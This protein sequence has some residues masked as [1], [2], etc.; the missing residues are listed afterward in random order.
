MPGGG[1]FVEVAASAEQPRETGAGF[2][3]ESLCRQL[4]QIKEERLLGSR[5]R[6]RMEMRLLHH[7]M[8]LDHRI[9]HIAAT[10]APVRTEPHGVI[11]FLQVDQI[12]RHHQTFT[13][14]ARHES[15]PFEQLVRSPVL[16][17]KTSC[18]K[19]SNVD[20]TDRAG[21]FFT[22]P[23]MRSHQNRSSRDKLTGL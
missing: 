23:R 21:R 14:R 5:G 11:T 18:L 6:N 1:R 22:W 4:D 9:D 3:G 19:R 12:I 13:A 2:A 16:S 15:P 17:G 20:A 10:Q 7:P 8:A